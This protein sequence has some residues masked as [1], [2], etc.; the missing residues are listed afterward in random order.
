MERKRGGGAVSYADFAWSR[1]RLRLH[2]ERRE[3]T[4]RHY[5]QISQETSLSLSRLRPAQ[6]EQPVWTPDKPGLRPQPPPKTNLEKILVVKELNPLE[7]VM[8][9]PIFGTYKT[10]QHPDP[11]KYGALKLFH[12]DNLYPPHMKVAQHKYL[13]KSAASESGQKA[14]N[15][16]ASREADPRLRSKESEVCDSE[17]SEEGDKE[18]VWRSVH[19]LEEQKKVQ[20]EPEADIEEM[21]KYFKELLFQLSWLKSRVSEQNLEK[22]AL[23]N[24]IRELVNTHLQLHRQKD[25]LMSVLSL[26]GLVHPEM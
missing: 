12:Y 19:F 4:E 5:H 23:Y 18:P 2:E 26:E 1:V 14:K 20:E 21:K 25:T 3:Q 7:S 10:G 9:P 15:D 6:S 17:V 24:Q 13:E 11:S 16:R 22:P 8:L